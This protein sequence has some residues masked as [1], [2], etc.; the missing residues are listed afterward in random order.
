[1]LEERGREIERRS[2]R[3]Q[4]ST[5]HESAEHETM[6]TRVRSLHLIGLR[7]SIFDP[8]QKQPRTN[9]RETERE[10]VFSGVRKKCERAR[11]RKCERETSVLM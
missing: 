1:M 5:P 11:E 6:R 7:E 9:P 10:E 8:Q 4:H 2:P 3:P